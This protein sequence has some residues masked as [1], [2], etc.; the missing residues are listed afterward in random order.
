V[1]KAR[2]NPKVPE[3]IQ[4]QQTNKRKRETP[5]EETGAIKRIKDKMKANDKNK[6]DKNTSNN[7]NKS[8]GLK[9]MER[10]SF[11]GT[12]AE[13][14]KISAKIRGKKKFGGKGGKGVK[15]T[16]PKKR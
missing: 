13:P 11:E 6:S 16:Q 3:K 4:R 9:K 15:R 12:R 7:Q 1:F 2:K 5:K 14:R 8:E 10:K